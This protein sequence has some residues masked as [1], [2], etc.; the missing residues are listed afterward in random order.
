[1]VLFI[2][3]GVDRANIK[4]FFPMGV[5]ETLVSKGQAAENNQENSNQNRGFHIASFR[6]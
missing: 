4:N 3:S 6:N 1:M 2:R 5:S